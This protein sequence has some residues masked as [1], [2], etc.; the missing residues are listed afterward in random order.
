[1]QQNGYSRRVAAC[2][3]VSRV[4]PGAVLERVLVD[5]LVLPSE[6]SHQLSSVCPLHIT[7][8]H[9]VVPG[10]CHATVTL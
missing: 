2:R 3:G 9:Q 8:H 4:E 10:S 5:E 1:M 7:D 6:G